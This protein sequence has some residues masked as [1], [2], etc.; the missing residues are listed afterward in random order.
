M[1]PDHA[2]TDWRAIVRYYDL[3]LALDPSAAPRLGRAVALAEAGEPVPARQHLLALLPQVPAA[4]RAHTLAALARACE[5]LGDLD[6]ARRWLD[7]AVACAPHAAD[8]RTL[9]RRA[10]ALGPDRRDVFPPGG[11]PAP[12]PGVDTALRH[13]P[14]E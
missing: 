4:L 7:E 8:A 13:G 6:A 12:Q 9:A 1:A 14:D 2:R 3:L 10:E 11:A 5:R